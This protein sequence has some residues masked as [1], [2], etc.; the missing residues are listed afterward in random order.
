MMIKPP[1]ALSLSVKA[2]EVPMFVSQ[3]RT[4][5]GFRANKPTRQPCQPC[6]PNRSRTCLDCAAWIDKVGGSF[7]PSSPDQ[8]GSCVFP[9]FETSMSHARVFPHISSLPRNEVA[10]QKVGTR[11]L[12]SLPPGLTGTKTGS[13]PPT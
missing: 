13:L 7:G 6:Q 11:D 9:A 10:Q 1:R 2:S 12:P 5:S 3:T 8:T 4:P